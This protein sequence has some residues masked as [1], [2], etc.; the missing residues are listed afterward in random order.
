MAKNKLKDV[1][2]LLKNLGADLNKKT[3]MGEA[4]RLWGEMQNFRPQNKAFAHNFYDESHQWIISTLE[5]F[6]M[7]QSVKM[8]MDAGGKE[9]FDNPDEVD[10]H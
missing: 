7:M 10:E 8:F 6:I 2:L 4:V 9:F 3:P 1:E 5:D